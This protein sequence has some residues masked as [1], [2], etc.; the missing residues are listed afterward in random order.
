MVLDFILNPIF[1]PFL[2]IPTLLAIII[3]SFIIS[4]I[5]TVIYKYTTD[6]NLM[7]QLKDEMKEFQKEVKTLKDN[8]SKAM[9]VQKKAMQTN[10]KYMMQ[11]MK[12]TLY[13]FIPII[14]I[15]GWMNAHF[16]FMPIAQDQEFSTTLVTYPGITG[17]AQISVSDGLE[18]VGGSSKPIENNQATWLLKGEKGEYLVEYDLNEKKY[19]NEIMIDD[20]TYKPASKRIKDKVVDR[21]DTKLEKRI[22]LDLGFWKMGWLITYIILAIVFSI[23]IRKVIK[24]Y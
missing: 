14:L 23:L 3:L 10:M 24:V 21:I 20:K 18:V 15:F 7:K 13:S 9:E 22:V 6:Q 1:S 17:S 8:P 12:S 16:A 19:T 11:S 2:K 4:L 5:V